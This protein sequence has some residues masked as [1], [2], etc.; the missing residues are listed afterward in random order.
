MVTTLAIR[1]YLNQNPSVPNANKVCDTDMNEIK[2]VVNSN[3]D[4][5]GSELYYEAGDIIEVG[6]LGGTHYIT[7]GYIT[8]GTQTVGFTIITPKRLDHVS[9][10]SGIYNLELALRGISG[11][12]NNQ[13]G[14]VDYLNNLNYTMNEVITGSNAITINLVKSSAF[15]NTTN[16][17]PVIVSGHIKLEVQ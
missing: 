12:L 4:E 1:T 10:V 14:T 16:N 9:S 2:S 11:Y 3:Y 7:G 8:G 5:M 13:S 6:V 17:T 15:T